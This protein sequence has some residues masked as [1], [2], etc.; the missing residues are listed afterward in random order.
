MNVLPV[1][2]LSAALLIA[3]TPYSQTV[4]AGTGLQRCQTQ[5]GTVLYTDKA[6]GVLGADATPISAELV[7]RIARE[8]A[9]SNAQPSAEFGQDDLA[10]TAASARRSLPGGCARSPTQ[11]AMDLRGAFALGDVNR[12]AESYYWTGLSHQEGQRIMQRLE[13]F[14]DTHVSDVDYFN[15]QI[16]TASAVHT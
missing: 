2:V 7:T 6:C 8:E 16:Q 3:T 15:A 13:Q 5:A 10:L 1:A 9:L 12:I 4:N 11:L 14:T